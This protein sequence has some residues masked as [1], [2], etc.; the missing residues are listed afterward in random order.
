LDDAPFD[1]HDPPLSIAFHDLRDVYAIPGSQPGSPWLP[2]SQGFP[3]GLPDRRDVR[4]QA[5]HTDQQG[6]TARTSPYVSDHGADQAPI[7]VFTHSP[8][9]PQNDALRFHPDLIGLHLS[10]VPRLLDQ[11]FMN[12]LTLPASLLLQTAHRVLIPLESLYNRLHRTTESQQ[13]H[14]AGNRLGAFLRR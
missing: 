4:A 10:Q 13:G 1:R 7:A 6:A 3:K 12:L 14:D 2:G 5:I 9:Q 8:A 11:V